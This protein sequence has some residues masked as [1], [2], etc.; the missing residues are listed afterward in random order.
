M[1]SFSP[2]HF[3]FIM[4]NAAVLLAPFPVEIPRINEKENTLQFLPF[5]CHRYCCCSLLVLTSAALFAETVISLHFRLLVCLCDEFNC[6]KHHQHTFSNNL[7]LFPLIQLA[8][9]YVFPLSFLHMPISISLPSPPCQ[10]PR[11][12]LLRTERE[13]SPCTTRRTLLPPSN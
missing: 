5:C 3:F 11:L 2:T 8:S 1:L 10:N 4:L 6:N 12:S 9:S 13:E 7:L